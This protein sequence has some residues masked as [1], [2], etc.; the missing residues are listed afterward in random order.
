M[1]RFFSLN[2][3]RGAETFYE[4][5]LEWWEGYSADYIPS[6]EHTVKHVWVSSEQTVKIV[7]TDFGEDYFY[8][9][10]TNSI[11]EVVGS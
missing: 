11:G 2:I 8:A 7:V 9:F 10:S 4:K 5:A 1:T 6:A 3:C